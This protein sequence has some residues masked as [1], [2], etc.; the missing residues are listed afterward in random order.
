MM[1]YYHNSSAS[2]LNWMH[3]FMD[4]DSEQQPFSPTVFL[5]D[6]SPRHPSPH[7]SIEPINSNPHSCKLEQSLAEEGTLGSE[8]SAKKKLA[9]MKSREKKKKRLELLEESVRTLTTEI[10]TCDCAIS[11][12]KD[13]LLEALQTAASVPPPTPRLPPS[14]PSLSP[15][16]NVPP[17]AETATSTESIC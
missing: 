12:C 6:L 17:E 8:K 11:Q 10:E 7:F 2:S 1:I 4:S 13:Q 3:D 16:S 15:S 14:T 5:A 9:G